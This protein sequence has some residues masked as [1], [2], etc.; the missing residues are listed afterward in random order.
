MFV[1]ILPISIFLP[2]P[3]ET[4]LGSHLPVLTA[5]PMAAWSWP[6]PGLTRAQ[7]PVV[8]LLDSVPSAKLPVHLLLVGVRGGLEPQNG[9]GEPWPGKF[10]P[11]QGDLE[12]VL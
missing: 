8:T 2:P 11:R 12:P 3:Q 6:R 5:G 7:S 10:Q 1:S 9:V 4:V